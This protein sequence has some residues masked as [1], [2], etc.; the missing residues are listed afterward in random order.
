MEWIFLALGIPI[1]IAANW[2][3]SLI[4]RVWDRFQ[5]GKLDITGHW[6][7]WAPD[8][9]GRE[10]SIGEFQYSWLRRR[11]EFNGTNYT[12]DGVPYCHWTTVASSLDREANEFSYN[13]QSRNVG[14]LHTASTGFGVIS[15]RRRRDKRIVPEDGY[16]MYRDTRAYAVSHSMVRLD[17]VPESRSDNAADILARVFPHEWAALHPDQDAAPKSQLTVVKRGETASA[18]EVPA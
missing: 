14:A 9:K 8:S 7:E 3:G 15:L 1:G 2:G 13:F 6:A 12:S 4:S 17:E 10:F 5:H 16:F 18:E 11:I